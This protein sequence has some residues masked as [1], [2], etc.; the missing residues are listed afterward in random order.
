MGQINP[1]NR[2]EHK[3][4]E[5]CPTCTK[6]TG[7]DTSRVKKEMNESGKQLNRNAV[8]L[9]FTNPGSDKHKDIRTDS[10]EQRKKI[11]AQRDT[12]DKA[13]KGEI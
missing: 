3:D 7:T 1:V 4:H 2:L 13:R 8:K 11:R 5:G 6:K 12:L 9:M 10:K